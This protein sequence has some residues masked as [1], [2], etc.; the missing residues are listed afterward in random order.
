MQMDTRRDFMKKMVGLCAA[1]SAGTLVGRDAE[2][3]SLFGPNERW[4]SLGKLGDLP[5][6]KS[7]PIEKAVGAED[8][9]EVVRP[10]LIAQRRGDKVHVMSTKC[11]HLG[12]EVKPEADGSY[13]C[14]CHD[15]LFDKSGAVTKGPAKKPLPWYA[16]RITDSGEVQVDTETVVAAP[17]I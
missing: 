12:C 4:L 2:A 6:G 10:K 3:W 7:L 1:V 9:R 11:T 15:S 16:V 13:H 14:P 17:T 5:D 8:G